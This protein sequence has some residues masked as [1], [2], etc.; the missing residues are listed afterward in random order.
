MTIPDPSPLSLFS[1]SYKFH[2]IMNLAVYLSISH[3]SSVHTAQTRRSAH[4]NKFLKNNF[5]HML[6]WQK[7]VLHSRSHGCTF[8]LQEK[9]I[10]TKQKNVQDKKLKKT[11]APKLRRSEFYMPILSPSRDEIWGGVRIE[12]YN[13]KDITTKV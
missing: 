10:Y 12:Q 8:K 5:K 6:Y 4:S 7:L 11:C 3:P 1:S 13:E 2:T 9:K